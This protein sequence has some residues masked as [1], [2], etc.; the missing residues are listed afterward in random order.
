MLSRIYY[1]NCLL[2]TCDDGLRILGVHC[3]F[4]VVLVGF[5]IQLLVA[6][7]SLENDNAQNEHF[8][9]DSQKWPQ[10]SVFTDNTDE[11]SGIGGNNTISSVISQAHVDPC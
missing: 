11:N 8:G 6:P 10:C 3:V 7:T 1:T 9:A 2:P 4:R 5:I